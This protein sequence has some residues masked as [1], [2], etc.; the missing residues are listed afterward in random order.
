MSGLSKFKSLSL[1]GAAAVV[2]AVAAPIATPAWSAEARE[3][4]RAAFDKTLKGKTVA[5]AP[6]WLGV[7]ESEW[8]RVMKNHFD[9]YGM[10][11]EVRDANFKSDVQLQAVSELINEH[12][13]VLIVQNPNVTL[14]AKELKR[15]MEAGSTSSRSTWPPIR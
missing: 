15:A 4:L 9:D 6:V 3:E 12:P 13:D 7:L 2:L 11:F 5:W 1:W 14:L 10:K 8:T